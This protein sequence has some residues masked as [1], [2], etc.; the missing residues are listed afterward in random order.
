[1]TMIEAVKSVYSNYATFSGRARR[2]EYWWWFLAYIIII[3]VLGIIEGA[4]FGSGT[5]ELSAGDGGFNASFTGGILTN[6]FMIASIIPALAVGVRRLHD[7]DRSGWWLLISF[8]PL[9]GWLILL[10]WNVQPGT[11]G[12]NRFGAPV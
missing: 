12:Q 10:Y 2:S 6:I 4:V 3:I 7:I 1:M 9:I 11:P 5:A 8:I